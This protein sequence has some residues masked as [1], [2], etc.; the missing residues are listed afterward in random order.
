LFTESPC[1]TP[2]FREFYPVSLQLAGSS[3]ATETLL[4]APRNGVCVGA[5]AKDLGRQ[6]Q[7]RPGAKAEGGDAAGGG[8]YS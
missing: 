1:G 4:F 3:Q 5:E 2:N 6:R 7:A 8:G